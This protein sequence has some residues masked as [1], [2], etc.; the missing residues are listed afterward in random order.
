MSDCYVGEIRNF[1]FQK[2]PNGWAQCNGQL[3]SVQQNQALFALIGITYG[4][5]G[6]TTFALPDLRSRVMVGNNLGNQAYKLGTKGGAENVALTQQQMPTHIHQFNVRAEAG[7]TGL[8]GGD[9]VSSSGTSAKITT[10]QALYAQPGTTEIPLNPGSLSYFGGGQAH[11]NLQP[12]LA[13]NYCIATKGLFP[14]RN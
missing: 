1:G 12:Y 11:S 9:Y 8:I 5:N 3:L 13:T 10:P 2:V 7:T 6:T 14:P 4:G